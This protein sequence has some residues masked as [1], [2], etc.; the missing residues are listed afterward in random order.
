MF[1]FPQHLYTDVR[2][3]D[4]YE[5]KVVY[6]LGEVE[7][8][9]NRSYKAAFIRL[10]DGERWYY[11]ST[12]NIENIQDEINTLASYA[13]PNENIYNNP[14]VKK[15]QVNKESLIKFEEDSVAKVEMEKKHDL[16]KEYFPILESDDLIKSWKAN[17]VDK[18]VVKEFYSSKGAE[19]T[20]DIQL[21]GLSIRMNFVD[22]E[23]R[24]FESYEKTSDAFDKLN[25]P[26]D[27]FKLRINECENFLF[28]SKPIESGKYTV[29]LSPLAAGVFAHESFG[30]KSEADFMIGDETMRKEWSIGKKVGS[31]I[32]S[33]VD[34]GNIAGSGYIPF[35]DEGTKAE[36][37]YLIKDGILS[38]R[39]HNSTTAE[40]LDEDLT[41]NARAV[42]FEFEPIV[43]MTTTYIETGDKS[44]DELFSEVEEG[45][46]IKTIKHGSGMSTF[47]IAPS[48]AYHVKNGKI[49]EPVNISVVSGNVMN[50][51]GE[52]DGLSNELELLSFVLG[53]CG[54]MEQYPLQVSFGGPYVRVKNLN[55]Q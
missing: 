39:L 15:L 52:I 40:Y 51:L 12:S 11:G 29:I 37:T 55:V 38:G 34:D 48:L 33:I 49:A 54:K 13:N 14:I 9:K 31:D 6:T 18:R 21:A 30:H 16:L 2:I 8:S 17:Y 45:I 46:Y 43:R 25:A 32:L 5:T 26:L 41:G 44:K 53:G 24:L 3:E 35:D 22:D 7:E 36:K 28:N 20:F 19:I 27:E 23:K 1:K 47:T 50:T 4:V 10:F 42:N